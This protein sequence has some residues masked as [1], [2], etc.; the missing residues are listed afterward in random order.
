DQKV[1]DQLNDLIQ[2]D[3]DAVQA[4]DLAIEHVDDAAAADDLEL[5]KSDHERHIIELTAVVT[6]L[7]GSP[8]DLG[9]DVK[10]VLIEG[11]TKLRSVTGTKGALKAMRMNEK[12][13]NKM[14]EKALE[15]DLPPV[16]LEIVL[17][18]RDD[19]RRHLA[20]IEAHIERLG[21]EEDREEV[22]GAHV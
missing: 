2:L 1:I 18:N 9:R 11:M 21:E 22:T 3:Y 16:A 7:G 13:T 20:A 10:G 6:V 15:L 12:I 5:F 19:E 4:Y 17:L 8:K 14:Y